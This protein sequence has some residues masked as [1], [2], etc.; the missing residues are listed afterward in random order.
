MAEHASHAWYR[1][2]HLSSEQIGRCLAAA[3]IRNVIQFHSGHRREERREK[4]LAATVTR[5]RVVDLAWARLHIGNEILQGVYRKR[6]DDDQHPGLAADQRNRREVFDRIE[7]ELRIQ[8]GADGVGL[9][10]KQ[11]GIAVGR[12]LGDHLTADGRARAG[13][14]LDDH[15]LTEALRQLL[16]DEAHRPVDRASRRERNDDAY[17]PVRVAL[18]VCRRGSNDDGSHENEDKRRLAPATRVREGEID[19]HASAH[20]RIIHVRPEDVSRRSQARHPAVGGHY[21]A[22]VIIAVTH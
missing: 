3:A 21:L 16:G 12:R 18:R 20:F 22:R 13:L 17:R 9:R 11:Q 7:R 15:A 14:V 8:G 10:R 4:V 6:G 19:F 2:L 5:R 1:H